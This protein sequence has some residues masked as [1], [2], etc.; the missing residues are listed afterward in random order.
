MSVLGSP[1]FFIRFH[2]S[3]K[4][5]VIRDTRMSARPP[6]RLPAQ[7]RTKRRSNPR[8]PLTHIASFVSYIDT[9]AFLCGNISP[10]ASCVVGGLS[11]T[12]FPLTIEFP[13]IFARGNCRAAVVQSPWELWVVRGFAHSSCLRLR[14][15]LWLGLLL[16]FG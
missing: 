13:I 12:A 5:R 14:A 2:L 7:G 8:L 11:P 9:Y 6:P 4:T 3:R 10:A 16:C 1:L 15:Y